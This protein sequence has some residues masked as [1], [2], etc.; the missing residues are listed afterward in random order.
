MTL[1]LLF[2]SRFVVLVIVLGFHFSSI[3]PA[4]WPDRHGPTLD[5]VAA[6]ED[7][8]G[9]PTHWTFTDNV[10]W[11]T[12]LHDEGHSSPVISE[13][14]IWL[15]A[16]TTDGTKQFVIAIDEKTG[17]VLHD[18]VVFENKEVE[19]LGGAQG[20]NN[21][22][23]P[24]CVL[25]PGAVYVHFGSYGTA[26][27]DAQTAD[28]IWQRRDLKC[29]HFRG[30]GS[31]PVL[32]DNKLILTFDGVDQQYTVALDTATGETIWRTDRST[33]YGDVGDDGRPLRD[34]DMRKAYCT[35]LVVKVGNQTQVLSVGAR[36]MQSYEVETGREI[37]TLRHNS[38]NAGIRPLWLTD[39][40]LVVINT[41]S[42]GAQHVAVKLDETTRGDIT[43]SHVV[44]VREHGNPRFAMPIE[45]DGLIFQVTDNGVLSCVDAANGDEIRKLR[46]SGDYR[47]SPILAGENLYFFNESGLGSVVQ[48]NRDCE[49]LAVNDVPEMATTACPAVSGG[50][51]FVR[52]KEFLFKIAV[53]SK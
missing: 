43:D 5:G 25:A 49:T 51:L 31:S 18:R 38:Y 3:C 48:G 21:Y 39:L 28:V 37:W 6:A 32:V 9:L 23:A 24:S 19:P 27:L 20:F 1:H 26:K 16:A 46:L 50:A 33:D 15:T 52:G 17:E 13:G 45:Q 29:Q 47:A 36:A 53:S 12:R 34:G 2:C 11:K 8:Q 30:P 41:G 44:W 22:A 40:K 42:R 7:A 10:A 14:K 35:P 4:Q